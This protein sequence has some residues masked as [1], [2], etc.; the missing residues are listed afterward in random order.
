M[1]NDPYGRAVRISIEAYEA[2]RLVA[3]NARSP[4]G[5]IASVAILKHLASLKT[6][7]P[8]GKSGPR[9]P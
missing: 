3:F 4:K 8:A 5:K 2:L 7:A 1:N 6:A 9:T